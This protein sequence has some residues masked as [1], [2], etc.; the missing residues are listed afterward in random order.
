MQGLF[1]AEQLRL[2]ER[3]ASGLEQG[4]SHF[5]EFKSALERNGDNV[6]PRDVRAICKD[7]AET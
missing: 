7:I 6:K 2:S 3:L 4:E 5:R 1:A